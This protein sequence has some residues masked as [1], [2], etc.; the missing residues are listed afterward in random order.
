M[1]LLKT[2]D[3]TVIK[4][5]D[6]SILKIS[7]NSIRFSDSINSPKEESPSK[8]L[9]TIDHSEWKNDY[10]GP[11]EPPCPILVGKVS[12]YIQYKRTGTNI[13][14]E[15]RRKNE[16][17]N[18]NILE[19]LV[20]YYHI[21][22]IGSNYPSDKFNPHKW[23]PSSFYDALNEEQQKFYEN[24]EKEKNEV[25]TSSSNHHHK[26]STTSNTTGGVSKNHKSKSHSRRSSKDREKSSKKDKESKYI[27]NTSKSQWDVG[28]EKENG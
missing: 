20:E 16:F 4:S 19:K 5:S 11:T 12:D 28:A 8:R 10:E 18:P 21:I 26:S 6:N 22:E 17:K 24:L 2:S 25:K 13:N 3:S 7:E 23:K 14:R 1:S 9:K 15:Y 27:H